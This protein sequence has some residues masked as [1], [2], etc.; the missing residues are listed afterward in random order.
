MFL[1]KLREKKSSESKSK[2]NLFWDRV[3]NLQNQ[4]KIKFDEKILLASIRYWYRLGIDICG[5]IC[6]PPIFSFFDAFVPEKL[7][8]SLCWFKKI[9]YGYYSNLNGTSIGCND[10]ESLKWPRYA[11]QHVTSHA[12][13]NTDATNVSVCASVV[14]LSC[15][16]IL[17]HL[18]LTSDLASLS[19]FITRKSEKMQH[20]CY[21]C[22]C[23][24]K[25]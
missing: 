4:I 13:I 10:E 20:G 19:N 11:E 21:K 3:D 16:W 6:Q 25:H 5:L 2:P 14:E 24:E 1:N 8:W 17:S 18:F 9:F 15:S 23:F 12:A 22:G 7:C